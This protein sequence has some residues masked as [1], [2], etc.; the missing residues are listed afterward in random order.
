MSV[1]DEGS[2]GT[3]PDTPHSDGGDDFGGDDFTGDGFGAETP[4]EA[5]FDPTSKRNSLRYSYRLLT[6]ISSSQAAP[7]LWIFFLYFRSSNS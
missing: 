6:F 1:N 7:G 4:A 5:E 3:A 2:W